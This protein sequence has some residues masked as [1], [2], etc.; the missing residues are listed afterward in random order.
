MIKLNQESQNKNLVSNSKSFSFMFSKKNQIL[1]NLR[2]ITNL[3]LMEIATNSKKIENHSPF[4][5]THSTPNSRNKKIGE[6]TLA[7]KMSPQ[8]KGED[9]RKKEVALNKMVTLLENK[10]L[11]KESTF[12][13]KLTLKPQEIPQ[14]ECCLNSLK[15]HLE[16]ISSKAKTRMP[17]KST[18]KTMLQAESTW[19]SSASTT[20]SDR[21]AS[22]ASSA[23]W[24]SSS[25]KPP[26]STRKLL[27]LNSRPHPERFSSLHIQCP[28][29]SYLCRRAKHTQIYKYKTTACRKMN[30]LLSR[31]VRRNKAIFW[32]RLRALNR[33]SPSRKSCSSSTRIRPYNRNTTQ[34][35]R[36]SKAN[37][38]SKAASHPLYPVCS[39]NYSKEIRNIDKIDK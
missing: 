21:I 2:W 8:N 32:M 22:R 13:T 35:Q 1:S 7:S 4:F 9:L 10:L 29:R 12:I 18:S 14:L 37:V 19:T 11:S 26:S 16:R 25:S 36:R 33:P 5:L 27:S 23:T 30:T 20:I 3:S 17:L 34:S 31:K 15:P 28:D 39:G 38:A 6:I 24:T